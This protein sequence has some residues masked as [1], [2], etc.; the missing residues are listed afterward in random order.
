[1]PGDPLRAVDGEPPTVERD[2]G[3][4]E[5]AVPLAPQVPD[6]VPGRNREPSRVVPVQ[7]ERVVPTVADA[8]P[9]LHRITL[10]AV[11]EGEPHAPDSVDEHQLQSRRPGRAAGSFPIHDRFYEGWAQL[12]AAVRAAY[13][14]IDGG[15][16]SHASHRV[17]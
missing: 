3:L 8:D 6:R 15:G 2:L 7:C 1:M 10:D 12:I 5:L 17:F 9:P 4:L 16:V 11:M 14:Q 13:H